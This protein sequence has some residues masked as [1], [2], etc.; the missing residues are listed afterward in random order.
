MLPALAVVRQFQAGRDYPNNP[1][2]EFAWRQLYLRGAMRPLY[3][4][5]GDIKKV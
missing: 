4:R 2:A 3:F 1:Y 5:L